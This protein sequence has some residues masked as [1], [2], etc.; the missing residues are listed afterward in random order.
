MAVRRAVMRETIDRL[1]SADPRD[2]FHRLSAENL[3]RWRVA[4]GEPGNAFD[5]HVLP[6]DWDAVALDL[7]WRQGTLPEASL[8]S[9]G[10]SERTSIDAHSDASGI[11]VI[12]SG[13]R[14]QTCIRPR[15]TAF[16]QRGP[17]WSQV[18]GSRTPTR[19]LGA[20]R[21]DGLP[22]PAFSVFVHDLLWTAR[23]LR[24][25]PTF[26]PGRR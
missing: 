23:T 15:V 26:P 19:A 13:D 4:A 9:G 3:A 17:L 22:D 24:R 7:T 11:L 1:A 2:R 5:L 16:V 8:P 20:V 10:D 21:P 14:V 18:I 12:W 25:S 6:G